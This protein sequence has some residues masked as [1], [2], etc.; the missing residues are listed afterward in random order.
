MAARLLPVP[1]QTHRWGAAD[2]NGETILCVHGLTQHG[3]V[4]EW[5]GE[6]LAANGSL[7]VAV[8]L[9]GHGSSRRKPPWNTGTHVE[10][11]LETVDAL[12]I[13]RATWIGHSFGGRLV[14]ELA[15]RRPERVSR[16]VL[17]DPGLDV[18]PEDALRAAET[19]RLDWSFATVDGAVNALVSAESHVAAPRATV[20]AYAKNDLR[21]GRDDRLRFRYCPSAVVVA[22][23]EMTLAPPAPAPVP[24]LIVRPDTPLS[25]PEAVD[26]RYRD[27]L[28]DLA[29]F[30][31]VP[32]G[33]N[34]LWESP[35]ETATAIEGF[36]SAT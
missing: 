24:T 13:D 23:S 18:R 10:D 20:E 1:L 5:L 19:D 6:R 3:G 2:A 14:A 31:D 32:N 36:L 35:N 7:V 34:V 21:R 8:D 29:S 30:A 26:Q 12:G 9:R 25:D 11:L 27:E 15:A 16:L 17:L 22:W 28:G 33:H 4:F